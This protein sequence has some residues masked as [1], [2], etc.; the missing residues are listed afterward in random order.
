MFEDGLPVDFVKFFHEHGACKF[1]DKPISHNLSRCT[2]GK[3]RGGGN[4]LDVKFPTSLYQ[5]HFQKLY[6]REVGRAAHARRKRA[7]ELNGGTFSKKHIMHMHAAQRGMCYFCGTSIKLGSKSL[8]VDHYEPIALG[9]KNDLAN[10]VLTCVRCNLL[11]NAMHGDRYDTKARKLRT[12][13]FKAILRSMRRDLKAYK[14]A[15]GCGD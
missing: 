6:D 2:C 13:E 8:H 1:C 9:G 3:P 11:K 10:M 4:H 14:Q 7:I 15:V 5:S 12:P